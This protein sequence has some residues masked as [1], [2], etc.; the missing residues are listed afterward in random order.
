MNCFRLAGIHL[1]TPVA[2]DMLKLR[3]DIKSE[4]IM[5]H[6]RREGTPKEFLYDFVDGI[7][8]MM[9]CQKV[10]N[11][12]QLI[13]GREW[14]KCECGSELEGDLHP[15]VSEIAHLG[16]KPGVEVSKVLDTWCPSVRT[17]HSH[18]TNRSC[19]F[20]ITA[21]FRFSPLPGPSCCNSPGHDA[22]MKKLDL[23]SPL[24]FIH[25]QV[26]Y[27]IV[28][29]HCSTTCDCDK[30]SGV[31]NDCVEDERCD[32]CDL[33]DLSFCSPSCRDVKYCGKCLKS[34]C[35]ECTMSDFCQLCFET[36]CGNCG[37][38]RWGETVYDKK[39]KKTSSASLCNFCEDE[40]AT[41][42]DY[43]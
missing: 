7:R 12:K 29:S 23:S 22:E 2:K 34:V 15:L 20:S 43:W 5:S 41:L 37:H 32:R 27:N 40:G 16:Q 9:K 11:A 13:W 10:Y 31:C 8:C 18:C 25:C 26:C 36:V 4:P 38:V 42:E 21:D 14:L 39:G 33:C 19:C 30:C 28:C 3:D 35:C 1:N 17:F 6:F 24:S